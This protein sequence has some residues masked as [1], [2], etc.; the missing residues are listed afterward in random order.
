MEKD[1]NYALVGLSTLVLLVGLIVFGFWFARIS[2][3]HDYDVYDILFEGPVRGISQGSETH[4]NGIKVGEVTKIVLQT[5]NTNNVIARVRVT[6]DVPIRVDSYASLEPQGITGLNYIQITA[7]TPTKPLLKSTTPPEVVPVIRTQ[8]STLSDLLEGGGNVLTR[9]IQALDRVNR[10]LSDTNIKTFSDTLADVHAVSSELR[11]KKSVIADTQVAIQ[12]ADA[13][14]LEVTE[15]TKTTRGLVD[16]DGKR[17]LKNLADA[18]EQARLATSE[19]R[20]VVAK[21]EAPAS[22][23]TANGLPQLTAA[24]A[25]LQT[26]ADSIDRL[27]RQIDADPRGL[28][29]RPPAAEKKVPR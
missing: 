25:S 1:A 13:A 3:A 17:T 8:R 5:T 11:D 22:N 10:V 16:G 27:A 6:S 2:F 28:V 7:G 14:I 21:L 23:F 29:S 12:H 20:A 19:L 18:A 4:F 9:T 26:A 15:L 24:A